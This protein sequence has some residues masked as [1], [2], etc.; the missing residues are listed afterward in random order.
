[1]NK[2]SNFECHVAKENAFLN[3]KKYN[4]DLDSSSSLLFKANIRSR[5]SKNIKYFV[6]LSLDKKAIGVRSILMHYC[7]CRV[8]SRLVGCCSH[9]TLIILYFSYARYLPNIHL[10]G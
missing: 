5:H 1:M 6:F 9:V 3:Y 7:T 8:G 2:N 10:P 4:I